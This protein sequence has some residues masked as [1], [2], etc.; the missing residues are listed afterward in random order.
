MSDLDKYVSACL[1]YGNVCMGMFVLTA[2]LNM[3]YIKLMS[4]HPNLLV[5]TT[6]AFALGLIVLGIVGG[7]ALAGM[8]TI[9]QITQLGIFIAAASFV[10]LIV[11]ACSIWC[12]YSEFEMAIQIVDTAADYYNAT[13]RIFLLSI[14]NFFVVSIV[15]VTTVFGVV[16][17][18]LSVPQPFKLAGIPTAFDKTTGAG[19]YA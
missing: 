10:L 19:L 7:A 6:I 12:Y 17:Y 1:P 11:F 15:F 8:S 14:G 5:K 3:L 4:S 16:S 2:I 18:T 13:L 9:S